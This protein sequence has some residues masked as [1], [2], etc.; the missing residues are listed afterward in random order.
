ML[1]ETCTTL[2]EA[3]STA[4]TIAKTWGDSFRDPTLDV[5]F[6]GVSDVHELHPSAYWKTPAIEEYSSFA[7]FVQLVRNL[8]DT[9]G[10]NKWDYYCLARQ[11]GIPTR[12]LDWCEGFVQALFF[13]FDGWNGK[14]T[15]C[16]W[17][18]RPDIVNQQSVGLDAIIAPSDL[19]EVGRASDIWLPELKKKSV[20]VD[21]EEW[22]N[23]KPIAVYPSRS[24][25]RIIG[26]LGTF[27]VHG[28]DTR[29]LNMILC[30]QGDS[31]AF[32]GRIDFAGL[33]PVDTKRILH[34]YGLRQCV[35]YPDADHIVKDIG[36]MY[37]W[38]E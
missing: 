27:T 16:V 38:G 20:S 36:Y 12:L 6:R 17:I 8:S 31:D 24:N 10:F 3:I 4:S 23:E 25:Q 9:S 19:S 29:P 15:P 32:L 35:I 1:I 34:Y 11:H 13:A 7:T 18:L 14:G 37:R 2:D 33:D 28:T 22:T 21:G 5:W 30:E 26:Q